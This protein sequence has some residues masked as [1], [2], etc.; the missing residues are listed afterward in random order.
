M[1]W[2]SRYTLPHGTA[3]TERRP[4]SRRGCSTR[5]GGRGGGGAGRFA[6]GAR[7]ATVGRVVRTGG[8][9]ADGGDPGA[10]LDG[11]NV[12]L[13]A[14]AGALATSSLLAGD[15]GIEELP[16]HTAPPASATRRPT[17]T[18]A[19]RPRRRFVAGSASKSMSMTGGPGPWSGQP[20]RVPRR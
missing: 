12:S 17:A 6:T 7:G 4:G 8:D 5:A 18:A 14:L 10:G 9:V 19:T 3:F 16:S 2:P 15:A 13:L 20:I 1:P 11:T